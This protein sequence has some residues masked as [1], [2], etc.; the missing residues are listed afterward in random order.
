MRPKQLI[1]FDMD[2]TLY[3]LRGGS[4]RKSPLRRSVL[5]N[6][7][8]YIAI[9]L[10]QSTSSAQRI[11]KNIQKRYGE[12]ISIGLEKEF[13]IDRHDYFNT[14]WDIPARGIVKK[15]RNSRKTL[16]A[17]REKYKL[18]LVSDAPRA[19][20]N[21]VLRELLIQDIFR[22]NIFSGE[23][24]RRKGFGNAFSSIAR[25]LKTRPYNCIAVGD[26]E[27]TDI[28]PAKKL[29]MYTVFIHPKKRSRIADVTIRSLGQLP[30]ALDS[31]AKLTKSKKRAKK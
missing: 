26:Q 14:V 3:E 12:Q 25:S 28:I 27:S 20:I 24:T 22:N 1:I 5:N 15:A 11:L 30:T 13:K 8:K 21:N 9:K 7:Q 29:S 23:G 6:A 16:L 10:S 2:G 19:W 31:I 4:Y 17:L 18:A